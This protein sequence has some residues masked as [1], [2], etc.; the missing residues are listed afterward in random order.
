MF[1][2]LSEI[3]I[4]QIIQKMQNKSCE[5]DIMPTNV[6][7]YFLNELLPTITQLVNQ[8]L[9]QGVFPAS[10]KQAVIRPL[11]KKTGLELILANYRPVSNLSFLSKLIEKATLKQF[12][13]HVSAHN[14]LPANQSAY[15]QFHC[16]ESSLLRLVN[17][18]LNGMEHQEVTALIAF[19]LSAAF[20]TVDH[21]ILLEVLER[22][23]GVR[24]IALK[25]VDSYLRTR[26][27]RI[28]INSQLSTI[29]DLECSAPREAA[30]DLGYF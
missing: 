22:Q 6:M 18:I 1:K 25:W 24:G 21:G 7:K 13:E 12:N 30:W 17:D 15:R 23:Y 10:W 5:L 26:T 9:T 4:K 29:R 27:C 11:L 2:P 8:S 19:D 20:D 16:C 3:D 28:S 14:L